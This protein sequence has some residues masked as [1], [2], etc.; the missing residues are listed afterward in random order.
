MS[1]LG[2]MLDRLAEEMGGYILGYNDTAITKHKPE[3]YHCWAWFT[4]H[5]AGFHGYGMTKEEAVEDCLD[6]V[7]EF[8]EGFE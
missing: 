4:E 5:G 6:Q 2:S 8:K 3:P 7:L 1:D